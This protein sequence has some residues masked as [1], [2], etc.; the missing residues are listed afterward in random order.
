MRKF[1]FILVLLQ[2]STEAKVFRFFQNQYY[3]NDYFL[4]SRSNYD[5]NSCRDHIVEEEEFYYVKCDEQVLTPQDNLDD[6]FKDIN[7]VELEFAK[8]KF[9][10]DLQSH[11]EKELTVNFS[12]MKSLKTCL[13]GLNTSEECSTAKRNILEML[14][15]D[16][17]RMRALMAQK[18]FPGVIF[19][20]TKPQ[21]FRNEIEHSISGVKPKEL[22]ENE[23]EYLVDHTDKLEAAF[24]QD[25]LRE[26]EINGLSE[27]V[28]EQEE[29]LIIRNSND[30]NRFEPM[31]SYRASLKFN[32][33]NDVYEKQY[34]DMIE[35]NP[36]LTLLTVTGQ[37]SDNIIF[38]DIINVLDKLIDNSDEAISNVKSLEGEDRVELLGYRQAVDTMLVTPPYESTRV[39]CDLAQK[40]LDQ[41]D[42]AEMMT[43][44]YIGLGA[45]AAGGLCAFT[46]VGMF[47]CSIGVGLAAE[48]VALAVNQRR[49]ERSQSAFFSGVGNADRTE[50]NE[51]SRN[52][53]LYLLPLSVASEGA[54]QAV[55]LI[56]RAPT[57]LPS[58]NIVN[59]VP[60]EVKPESYTRFNFE[61]RRDFEDITNDLGRGRKKLLLDTYNPGNK[62]ELSRLD[63]TYFSGIA[64]MLDYR[65]RQDFP[66]MSDDLIK[67]R[68]AK[69]LDDIIESCKGN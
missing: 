12:N 22:T 45:V 4:T 26:N 14:R 42:K 43:D 51:F 23:I 44:I 39:Q 18:S 56:R 24:T 27:C 48:G 67:R 41:N 59:N 40:L 58:R 31:V 46:G 16:L 50:N 13:Q 66:E 9:L 20:P 34:N 52:L 11:V 2:F 5:F 15:R 25:V 28:E 62:Y 36:L 19:S 55:K 33:Q 8:D 65:L 38:E 47:G 61:G 64:D 35:P 68:V 30:C 37:E 53:T 17:P 54:M 69:E 21:R 49:H 63:E 10:D 57:A 29:L 6:F 1:L 7:A 3:K 32:E 60:I